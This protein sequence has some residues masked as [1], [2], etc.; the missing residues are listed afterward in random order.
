MTRHEFLEQQ[1]RISVTSGINQRFHQDRAR[2]WSRWN[3]TVQIAVAALAVLGLC[4]SVGALTAANAWVDGASIFVAAMA[5]V[6][7]I[8]LN[9]SPIGDYAQDHRDLFRR[10]TDLREDIDAMLFDVEDEPEP[11]DVR[12]LRELDARLTEPAGQKSRLA[13]AS[14]NYFG[15]ARLQKRA[16]DQTAFRC[17]SRS[18]LRSAPRRGFS[19]AVRSWHGQAWGNHRVPKAGR[20]YGR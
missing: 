7:A 1:L 6:V 12:R 10:W 14:G 4:M 17:G 19:C 5:A 8:I 13:I 2:Y 15:S 16:V 18:L 20:A 3:Q 11:H 9:V